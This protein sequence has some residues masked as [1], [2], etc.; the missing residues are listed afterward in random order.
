MKKMFKILS[1]VLCLATLISSA[2]CEM[3]GGNDKSEEEN[4]SRDTTVTVK[5][6]GG[7][8]NP[9]DAPEEPEK[10]TTRLS[11][12]GVEY[13]INDGELIISG[14][15][16]VTREAIE[17]LSPEFNKVDFENGSFDIGDGAFKDYK[18]LTEVFFRNNVRNIG[19]EAF[20]NTSLVLV[21]FGESIEGIGDKAFGDN[22]I[23]MVLINNRAMFE[24]FDSR[25]DFGEVALTANCVYVHESF[26][27][28]ESGKDYT[29][30]KSVAGKYLTDND[31]LERLTN[32][33]SGHHSLTKEKY[34]YWN[35]CG[36]SG[37]IPIIGGVMLDR[38]LNDLSYD[39][40]T[41]YIE[42]YFNSDP[43]EGLDIVYYDG[44]VDGSKLD[45]SDIGTKGD[46]TDIDRG[47]VEDDDGEKTDSGSG[48][49]A[50]FVD[51][52][53]GAKDRGSDCIYCGGSGKKPC[54]SPSCNGGYITEYE[55]GQYMG[56]GP[57]TYE[58]K[59]DCPLCVGGQVTCYH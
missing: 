37:F 41:N 23:D 17:K 15:G 36:D 11:Q 25:Y 47:R 55:S 53:G 48:K 44:T 14:N 32:A 54:T 31:F 6:I 45:T 50:G 2:G 29:D 56:S 58:V 5:P 43:W 16:V 4:K 35:I 1:V 34:Q 24:N 49:S 20:R 46:S 28:F 30:Y 9:E 42:Y 39:P 22:I 27:P 52:G 10:G 57:T 21:A 19:A 7:E 13:L 12:D 8:D 38:M 3:F 26:I 18:N 51:N 33:T 40:E 59:K